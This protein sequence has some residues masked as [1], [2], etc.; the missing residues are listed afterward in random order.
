MEWGLGS[1][2]ALESSDISSI[3]GGLTGVISVLFFMCEEKCK[4]ATNLALDDKLIIQTQKIGAS[5][6]LREGGNCRY[7]RKYIAHK[8]RQEIADLF[9]KVDLLGYDYKRPEGNEGIG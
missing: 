8:K 5:Q 1:A 4:M 2:S 7:A 3:K 6:G 9:G